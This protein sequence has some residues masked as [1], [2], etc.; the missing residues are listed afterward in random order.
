[1]GGGGG[2]WEC[3]STDDET[4]RMKSSKADVIRED[5]A[6]FETM[7]DSEI[8]PTG[9]EKNTIMAVRS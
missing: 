5:H 3:R 9:N 1:M 6:R 2:K 7:T 8:R 4:D